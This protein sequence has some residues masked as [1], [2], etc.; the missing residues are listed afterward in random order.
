MRGADNQVLRK[1]PGKNQKIG[2]D[3]FFLKINLSLFSRPTPASRTG[4]AWALVDMHLFGE[5]P[6][7]RLQH[8]EAIATIAQK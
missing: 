8:D 2:T 3:L 4:K 6:A 1:L 7:I 5:L